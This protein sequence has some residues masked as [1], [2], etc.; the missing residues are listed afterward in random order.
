MGWDCLS[1]IAG[2]IGKPEEV[3][4]SAPR[5]ALFCITIQYILILGIACLV[6][7]EPAAEWSDGDLPYLIQKIC[8]PAVGSMILVS[9]CIGN[10]GQFT[11]ELMEDSYQLEGLA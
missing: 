3:M 5:A 11:A 9:S 2:Q 4:P 10:W 8:G 6:S 7:T 1:T